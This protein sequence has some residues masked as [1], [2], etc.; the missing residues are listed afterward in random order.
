MKNPPLLLIISA[1]VALT[2]PAPAHAY[3][4]PGTGSFLIQIL[5]AFLIGMLVTMKTIWTYVKSFFS[6]LFNR[7]HG[8]KKRD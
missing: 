8:R 1:V 7:Q 2:F 3:L 6:G 4:D 5:V